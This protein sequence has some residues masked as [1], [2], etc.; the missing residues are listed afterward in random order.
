[1]QLDYVHNGKSP[2][3]EGK[4]GPIPME[5]IWPVL[6]DE[7]DVPLY[8]GQIDSPGP[9]VS[10]FPYHRHYQQGGLHP[11]EEASDKLEEEGKPD[12]HVLDNHRV[13]GLFS[14]KR[15]QKNWS[16]GGMLKLNSN[17]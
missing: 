7:R 5:Q 2:Y 4:Y 16:K 15:K 14:I 13:F 11:E 9:P 6:P 1:M 12:L 10:K 8:A 17:V 3:L